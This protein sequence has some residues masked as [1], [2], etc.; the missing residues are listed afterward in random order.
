LPPND[1]L[2]VNLVENYIASLEKTGILM[3]LREKWITDAS[4]VR[5]LP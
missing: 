5:R 2:F 4:W 1:P 3:A